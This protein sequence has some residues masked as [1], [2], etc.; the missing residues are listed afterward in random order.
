MVIDNCSRSSVKDVVLRRKIAAGDRR[1][2]SGKRD[3]EP[4]CEAY[5]W[6]L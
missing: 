2:I 1:T 4:C 5:I 6:Y 3:G